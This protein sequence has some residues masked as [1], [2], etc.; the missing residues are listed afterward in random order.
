MGRYKAGIHALRTNVNVARNTAASYMREKPCMVVRFSG[1]GAG[2]VK[3]VEEM[4][5]R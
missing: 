5:R 3:P 4:W 2:L 1:R